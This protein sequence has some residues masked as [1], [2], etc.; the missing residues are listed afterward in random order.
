MKRRTLFPF[1]KVSI[2]SLVFSFSGGESEPAY[3]A[4][5]DF[6]T[7]ELVAILFSEYPIVI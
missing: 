5:F 3:N 7:I 2:L 4:K 6:E 1:T